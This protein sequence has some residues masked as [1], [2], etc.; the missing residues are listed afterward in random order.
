M[1]GSGEAGVE[2]ETEE[3]LEYTTLFLRSVSRVHE[4]SQIGDMP[5]GGTLLL[6]TCFCMCV[7][8]TVC[9]FVC[10]SLSIYCLICLSVCPLV[11]LSLC[12]NMP[13]SRRLP[14]Y[15]LMSIS[16]SH[17]SVC[18]PRHDITLCM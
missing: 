16:L 12:V 5:A 6:D 17:P 11:C 9:A 1:L 13:L 3:S 18:G 10:L 15:L 14:V 8:V 7:F 2:P 4:V